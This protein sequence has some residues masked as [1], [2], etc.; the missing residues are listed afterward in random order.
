MDSQIAAGAATIVAIVVSCLVVP[1]IVERR[2]FNPRSAKVRATVWLTFLAF[3]L[4]PAAVSGFVFSV[5]NSLPRQDSN[6]FGVQ[7]D[8]PPEEF[9]QSAMMGVPANHDFDSMEMEGCSV[10]AA[11][12]AGS[13]EIRYRRRHTV[14]FRTAIPRWHPF[15]WLRTIG[16][17]R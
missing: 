2:G 14:G 6:A 17:G 1:E 16:R 12:R 9:L 3:V 13:R 7:A 5:A 15:P 8:S 10:R 11:G 4:V